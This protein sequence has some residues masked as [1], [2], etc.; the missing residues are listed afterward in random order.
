MRGGSDSL[1]ISKLKPALQCIS[2]V[3]PNPKIL[4]NELISSS[5]SATCH[6]LAFK[7]FLKF[8]VAQSIVMVCVGG[9]PWLTMGGRGKIGAVMACTISFGS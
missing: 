2:A 7:Q 5:L 4:Q 9:S 8:Y 6:I 3:F 1:H